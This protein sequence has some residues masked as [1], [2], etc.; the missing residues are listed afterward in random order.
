MEIIKSKDNNKIKYVRSLNNK[1]N[2]DSE[3][4][5]I[6][7]GVKFVNEA[8]NENAQIKLILLII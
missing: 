7:E 8:I 2:R 1:K 6:V 3:G 4:S 5:F